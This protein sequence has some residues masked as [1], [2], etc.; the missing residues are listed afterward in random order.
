MAKIDSLVVNTEYRLIFFP[1]ATYKRVGEVALLIVF[2]VPVYRRVGD[3]RQLLGIAYRS[4]DGWVATEA[5]WRHRPFWKVVANSC[6]R[7]AQFWTSRPLLVAT[8]YEELAGL[9]CSPVT[10]GYRLRRA[11]HVKRIWRVWLD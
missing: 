7:A 5:G 10:L 8:D 6:L 4:G 11:E 1:F 2:G 3:T 9:D